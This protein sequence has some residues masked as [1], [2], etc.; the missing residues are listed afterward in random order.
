MKSPMMSM[1][2]CSNNVAGLLGGRF[3]RSEAAGIERENICMDKSDTPG[4]FDVGRLRS[5][6]NRAWSA[7][8]E[9]FDPEIRSIAAWTKWRFD[10]HTREDVV[11][12]IKVGIVQSIGRLESEQSLQAFVRKICVHRCIDALR[13]L[14]REQ[15]RLEPLGYLDEDGEWVDRT[16]VA[17]VGFDPVVSLQRIENVKVVQNALSR[18]DEPSRK[19]ILQFYVEGLSYRD[20]ARIH[21]IAVNTVGSRLSRCL[22]KLRPLLKQA[23]TEPEEGDGAHA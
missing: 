7:F 18:L 12:T 20:M 22:D 19:F 6:D 2:F 9:R 3:G 13:R 14:I 21:G 10:P 11:Q 15:G 16:F 1:I 8:F 5:G 4:D 17:D 23:E